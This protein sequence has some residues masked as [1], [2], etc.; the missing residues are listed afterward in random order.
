MSLPD[1]SR[2][3]LSIEVGS[4]KSCQILRPIVPLQW[5]D[6]D[7]LGGRDHEE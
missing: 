2:Y 7:I 4:C 3:A 5:L 6:P 1:R